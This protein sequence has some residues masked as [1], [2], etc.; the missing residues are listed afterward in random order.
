MKNKLFSL[1]WSNK[2][3]RT[4]GNKMEKN[5]GHDTI[6]ETLKL[7]YHVYMINKWKK[8]Q[9]T[10]YNN[11]YITKES[12]IIC[13]VSIKIKNY[14]PW[15]KYS[16]HR[17]FFLS[18]INIGRIWFFIEGIC[19]IYNWE[20]I[21]IQN[22]LTWN[23]IDAKYYM[24]YINKSRIYYEA[25]TYEQIIALKKTPVFISK[26]YRIHWWRY[27]GLKDCTINYFDMWHKIPHFFNNKVRMILNP[28]IKF[29]SVTIKKIVINELKQLLYNF[30]L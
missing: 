24:N 5:L 21:I 14:Q 8:P 19:L 20:T 25:I 2:K 1:Q 4:H 28:K 17:S 9:K 7:S 16:L 26:I 6:R 12:F 10:S 27:K 13:F 11:M 29:L 22:I 30:T 18:R 3:R 15:F 23:R